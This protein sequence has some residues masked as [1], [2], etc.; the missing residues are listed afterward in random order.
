MKASSFFRNLQ[1]AW[2][3]KGTQ[4]LG[5]GHRN[6][7]WIELFFDLVFISGLSVLN[8]QTF[9]NG[10][11]FQSIRFSYYIFSFLSIWL[12]WLSITIFS[13]QFE[14]NSVRHRFLLFFNMLSV[15]LLTLGIENNMILQFSSQQTFYILCF[16]VSRVTLIITW[17]STNKRK[18]VS[19]ILK[20]IRRL[21]K[22]YTATII[23]NT[24]LLLNVLFF[25]GDY[26]TTIII[27]GL[28][29]FF[30]LFSV[31]YVVSKS[32]ERV[33]SLHLG[34]FRERFGLFTMLILGEML[35]QALNAFRMNLQFNM[36]NLLS[37]L[38][39]IFYIFMFWWLYYDQVL[40]FKFKDQRRT[41]ATWI[42]FHCFLSF[43]CLLLGPAIAGLSGK[44]LFEQN[45]YNVFILL[46]IGLI[47]SLSILHYS[48]D[49]DERFGGK[50]RKS[51]VLRY[52]SFK[53]L[54]YLRVG[55]LIILSI[56]YIYE[57]ATIFSLLIPITFIMFFNV[58]V[59]LIVWSLET[60][61]LIDVDENSE[62]TY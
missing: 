34:H 30:E 23:A 3:K 8:S 42:F 50:V 5:V 1:K 2:F 17:N 35:I 26:K 48:L 33:S 52:L 49:I 10:F 25:D 59:G 45:Y 13:N 51:I 43:I 54:I 9:T 41:R 31:V 20:L 27:W 38:F 11:Q 37:L 12:I 15:G 19:P 29:L 39:I 7:S 36:T 46:N 14:N 28:L 62:L 32:Q 16:I 22:I 58:F 56:M 57:H 18:T 24:F 40:I 4:L 44:F 53:N 55:S 21:T 6:A 47:F 60:N 61:Q